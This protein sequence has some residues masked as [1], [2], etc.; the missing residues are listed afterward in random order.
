M[1]G[2]NKI[3]MIALLFPLWA[4]AQSAPPLT[5]VVVIDQLPLYLL[6]RNADLFG[7]GG[8]KRLE[9]DGKLFTE[10]RYSH[11]VTETGPGH[12]TI[13]TGCNPLHH[14][15]VSNVW[16]DS[17]DAEHYCFGCPDARRVSEI[18]VDSTAAAACPDNFRCDALADAWRRSYGSHAKI[19]SM[20]IKDRAAVALGG[21]SANLASWVNWSDGKFESS[22][23]YGNA[24]PEWCVEYNRNWSSYFDKT[25]EKLRGPESY[26][27]ADG[28]TLAYE[29]GDR[30][31]LGNSFPKSLRGESLEPDKAYVRRMLTSPFGNDYL[32][33]LALSC[34]EGERLG[35]D[36]VPDLLC[37]S[38]SCNDVCGHTFGPQSEEVIDMMLRTDSLLADLLTRLDAVAGAGNYWFAL[39]ADH[40]VCPACESSLAPRGVGGRIDFGT[41][42]DSLNAFLTHKFALNELPEGGFVL[43]LGATTNFLRM[44]NVRQANL[45]ARTV[46]QAAVVWLTSRPGVR[47]AVVTMTANDVEAIADDVLRRPIENSQYAGRLGDFYLHLRPYWQTS[48]IAATHGTIHEYDTHVPLYLMGRP[49]GTGRSSVVC[50]PTDA[51]ASLGAAAGVTWETPRD[52]QARLSV[53]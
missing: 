24:L 6:D 7:E 26:A 22:S 39:T 1:L 17:T 45:D 14:G 32:Y 25:W 31:G 13:S 34:L 10:C 41:M 38:F 51:A 2:L 48:S 33:G 28:D 35:R 8:F 49:F 52:G 18:G 40:G 12:A 9:R 11:A 37:V 50:D 3:L 16:Y 21:H 29:M 53:P 19:F 36:S 46:A 43:D 5:V 23:Y 15:I 4:M 30:S 20:S 47:N 44:N 42:Q 27:G